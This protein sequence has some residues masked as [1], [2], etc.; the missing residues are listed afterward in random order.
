MTIEVSL[1]LPVFN[2]EQG[3]EQSLPIIESHLKS[4]TPLYEIILVDDGSSDNTWEAVQNIS[5][6]NTNIKALRFTRNFGKEGAIRAGITHASGAAVLIMDSDLQ[7][8]P[9]LIETMYTAWKEDGYMVVE[10]IKSFRGKESRIHKLG[11][12]I[13]YHS[14]KALSGFNLA[15]SSDFKLLDRKVVNSLLAMPERLLFFRGLCTWQSYKT[16]QI[17]FEVEARVAGIS[18]WSILKKLQLFTRGIT[19]FSALPLQIIGILGL[20][21]LGISTLLF[22]QT[23]WMKY[24]GHALS[25]F[26]TIIILLLI[27]GSLIMIGISI[28]GIY[29]AAIY[30]EIKHRPTFLISES[31]GF[32]QADTPLIAAQI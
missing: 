23:L 22:L 11:A 2:E 8:P 26:S 5:D 32:K 19:A 27:I 24:M 14:I 12:L 10:G 3:I 20:L 13:F 1:I 31:I 29:V 25:G 15:G 16:K 7:H 4:C 30:E 17:E 28:L 9:A 18:G 21:F 6:Q